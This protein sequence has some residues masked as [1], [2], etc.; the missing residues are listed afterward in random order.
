VIVP[1]YPSDPPATQ[2]S[3]ERRRNAKPRIEGYDL[4]RALAIWGMVTVHFWIVMAF[5]QTRP[6][7]L[8]WC[9]EML[10]G[11]AAA[12][13]VILAGI[14]VSLRT[15][16]AQA[17]ADA[18]NADS[19]DDQSADPIAT[20]QRVLIYRGIFLLIAGFLNLII[21]KGDILRVYGVSLFV[22]ALLINASNRRLLAAAVLCGFAFIALLFLSDYDS[23]WDWK[24]FTYHD[25]WTTSGVIRNLFY[26][27]F[28]SV[29]PWTG[30]LLFGMWLG[31]QRFDD[32]Q[33]CRR[34][35]VRSL[36]LA[37]FTE[38]LSALL[39]YYFHDHPHGLDEKSVVALFGTVSMPPLPLFLV[40]AGSMAV[41][42][43]ASSLLISQRFSDFLPVRALIACGQMA[44]TW[45][46]L[47]IVVGLGGLEALELQDHQS[48]AA[49]AAAAT[50][51]FV[52]ISLISL[53]VRSR[54]RRGPLEWMMRKVAG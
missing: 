2:A 41:A 54:G 18:S 24:T 21:W 42:V 6:A 39:V 14:G 50:G 51:F 48:L 10:D 19:L 40:A 25:L 22:A 27:G 35:L 53:V 1:N 15:A 5:H 49:A 28:R 13:F 45:Y 47:H 8:H 16:A 4:A 26:N 3:L 43:I 7:W 31:R 12:I 33:M 23:E 20:V 17:K 29:F 32:Q 11:R 46:V 38:I 52:A 37:V 30:L 34:V 9:I 44:F 36:G